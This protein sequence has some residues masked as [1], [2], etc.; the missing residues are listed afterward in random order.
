MVNSPR[1]S[2]PYIVA[3]QAQKEVTH[4]D[5]VNDLES[6]AQISVINATTNAPPASLAEG[7]SYIIGPSPTG[8]WAG[9][10]G[11]VASYYSGWRIKTPQEGWV[12]W[13]QDADQLV[14]YDGSAWTAALFAVPAGSISAPGL[15]FDGDSDTGLYAPSVDALAITAGGV[16]VAQF[17]S[18]ASAV[19]YFTFTPAATG[20]APALAVA[21]SDTNVSLNY[22]SKGSGTHVFNA[23]MSSTSTIT[24]S[25]FRQASSVTFCTFGNTANAAPG[26]L[27]EGSDGGYFEMRYNGGWQ[28]RVRA[29]S[30]GVGTGGT[31]MQ[32]YT[33]SAWADTLRFVTTA[34]AV[35][36]AQL[37]GAAT[38][39]PPVFSAQGSDTNIDLCL[40]PKGTGVLKLGNSG[41]FAANGSVATTMTALGP[42]G[43]STTIQEWLKIKNSSGTTQYIPC[44]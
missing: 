13:I 9:Q 20:N 12:A 22:N 5:A 41:S 21:G 6:L 17:P 29:T 34:S 35:N 7:D 4:N 38:G 30:G 25:G 28:G 36:C 1:F 43:S 40:M 37:S 23:A 16:N 44:Y 42:A 8:A 10:A 3:S 15:Y 14:I 2:I 32:N 27:F 18:A 24:A 33:G 31:A 26:V 11:K 19:N 39:S